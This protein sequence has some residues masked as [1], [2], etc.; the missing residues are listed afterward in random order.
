MRTKIVQRKIDPEGGKEATEEQ[1]NRMKSNRVKVKSSKAA[2]LE[3]NVFSHS[4]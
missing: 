4:Q 3:V 2:G 1:Q